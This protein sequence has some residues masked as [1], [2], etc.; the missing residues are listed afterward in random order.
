MFLSVGHDEYWSGPQRANVEAARDAGVNLAF[1]SGNEVFWKTRWENSID[2]SGTAA[3]DA[4]HL[5][6][7]PGQR[8]D[9]PRR[10][11]WTGT[12]RDP[13][14]SPP[15]DGGRR[16]T[17]SPAQIF[18][19]NC[20]ADQHGVRRPTARCGSGATRAWPRCRRRQTAT[21]AAGTLGY[22]WDEDVD[23]GFRPAG[24]FRLSDDDRQ[25]CDERPAST[26][27]R[28]SPPARRPT[29]TMYRAPSGALVFGAGTIQWSWGLDGDHDGPGSA[30]DVRIQQAT[31][32]L[33]ADMGVQPATL[34]RPGWSPP[35]QSTDTRRPDVDHHRRRPPAP[36]SAPATR[37]HRHRHRDRRRRRRVGGVEVSVDGGT[38][39]HPATGRG[40]LDLHV[41]RPSAPAPSSI[42]ARATDDSG[43]IESASAAVGV[44]SSPARAS[45]PLHALAFTARRRHR[46]TPARSRWASSS[47]PTS[48]PTSPA[49]GSTRAPATPAPTSARSGTPP[50]PSWPAP[51][52]PASRP[53]AGSRPA[54][55]RRS[56]S[57]RARRTWRRTSRPTAR[58]SV[59]Q[60]LRH[61]RRHAPLHALQNGADGGNGVYRY[62]SPSSFPT[63]SYQASN[64][65]VD[66][67]FETSAVDTTPPLV[68][69]RSPVAGAAEVAVGAG[70]GADV[71]RVGA[72][73]H[74]ADVV[75]AGWWRPRWRGRWCYDDGDARRR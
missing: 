50:A 46:R 65:W 45:V 43:N 28:T 52:S 22:E 31:V 58:Y 12:W 27:G 9:R 59:A 66:V 44:R 17:R 39:W 10:A 2:G 64:Y 26:T 70:R 42:K 55:P 7:D 18:K 37:R 47:A 16:R 67:V 29:L 24:L 25:T 38:T 41:S 33:F 11:E 73:R 57:R 15:A 71:Q 54:S 30:A 75:D 35:R 34:C 13:R 61:L 14:F 4:R 21:L 74:D 32:N 8:Q 40:E 20:C 49:S 56:R 19:V 5:Q 48:T 36:P 60:L 6:G 62:G 63:E 68:T 1:F 51:P 53:P 3:P 69:S 23:N 72:G